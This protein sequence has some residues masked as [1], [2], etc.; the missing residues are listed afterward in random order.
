MNQPVLQTPAYDY[1]T[2]KDIEKD[3]KIHA[4]IFGLPK[5]GKTALALTFPRPAV[6][7]FDGLGVEVAL[8][9]WFKRTHG[10][11][12]TDKWPRFK[13]FSD[14]VDDYGLPMTF[15]AF[16][17]SIKW[18]NALLKDPEVET[19]V[20]DSVSSMS[21]YA[22]VASLPVLNKR[23]RSQTWAHAQVDHMILMT[24]QDYGGEMSG[25]EQV[26]D[27]LMQVTTKNIIVLA[28]ERT[29]ET[30]SGLTSSREVNLTGASLRNAVARWFS[31]VWYLEAVA[32]KRYLRC[33]PQGFIK[34]VGSRLGLPATI[35][36][37]SYQKIIKLLGGV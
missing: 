9:P 19:I 28:H 37:P 24:R 8:S 25:I 16:F 32:G 13:S 21:H 22:R 15:D 30:E 4:L 12:I 20:I 29:E 34:G 10:H 1:Q 35:E 17:N 18:L 31:D 11:L 2:I 23:K 26:F 3:R 14:K 36:D 6:I 27:Q 5:T 7:D 33:D